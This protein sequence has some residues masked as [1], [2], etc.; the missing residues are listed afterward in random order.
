M[1]FFN[2]SRPWL[3]QSEQGAA[4]TTFSCLSHSVSQKWGTQIAK[5]PC[6]CAIL[7]VCKKVRESLCILNDLFAGLHSYEA[8]ALI[9]SSSVTLTNDIYSWLTWILYWMWPAQ[10]GQPLL[11]SLFWSS[12]EGNGTQK[13]RAWDRRI[14]DIH[15]QVVSSTYL[16]L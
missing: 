7:C 9:Q 1:W 8:T 11:P 12:S 13:R 16:A 10:W 3:G 2:F 15:P 4:L 6:L 14:C 5:S